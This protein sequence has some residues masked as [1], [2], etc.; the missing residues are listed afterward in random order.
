MYGLINKKKFLEVIIIVLL[1]LFYN[2]CFGF[3]M[4]LI[5]DINKFGDKK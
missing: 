4:Y 2:S 1:I 5:K 3:L